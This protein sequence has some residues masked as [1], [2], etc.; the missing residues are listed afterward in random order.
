MRTLWAALLRVLGALLAQV[1]CIPLIAMLP[2][3]FVTLLSLLGLTATP[4]LAWAAPLAPI[5]SYLFIVSIGFL[6][7]G[8][9]RCRW[10]PAS[11]ALVG[12]LLVF[13][14][15]YVLVVPMASLET[16]PTPRPATG[17]AMSGMEQ[18][19]PVSTSPPAMLGMLGRTN[20]SLFYAGVV[21]IMSSF[22]LVW[23][24]RRAQLCRLLNP[25]RGLRTNS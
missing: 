7:V 4:L 21:L 25:L 10:Q 19:T 9:L 20:A 23:W 2:A 5:A 18:A 11:V 22:G 24:R 17:E 8:H 6:V 12:G 1:S 16:P 13:L 14:A 15:M 3:G